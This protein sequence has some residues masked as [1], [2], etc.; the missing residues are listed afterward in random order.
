MAVVEA[1]QV[2]AGYL[3]NQA[4]MPASALVVA[5][6]AVSLGQT[7]VFQAAAVQHTTSAA[8]VY[9]PAQQT[10][11]AANQEVKALEKQAAAPEAASQP[12]METKRLAAAP[13]VTLAVRVMERAWLPAIRPVT[14]IEKQVAASAVRVKEPA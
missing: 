12:R 2:G 4:R 1:V 11:L 10:S 6:M 9:C 5:C 14:T 7:T 3:D 13:A 8:T